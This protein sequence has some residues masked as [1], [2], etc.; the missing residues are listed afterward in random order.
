MSWSIHNA[1]GAARQLLK[2]RLGPPSQDDAPRHRERGPRVL[3]GQIDI[4]GVEHRHSPQLELE[5]EQPDE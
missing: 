4:Y 2:A 1:A 5:E 3:D